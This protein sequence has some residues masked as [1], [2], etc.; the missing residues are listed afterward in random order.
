M[1]QSAMTILIS[2]LLIYEGK[3]IPSLKI[4]DNSNN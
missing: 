4:L 1:H 2:K 3:P